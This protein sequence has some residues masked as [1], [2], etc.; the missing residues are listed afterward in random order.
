MF[1][2][3]IT[4]KGFTMLLATS[5]VVTTILAGC[6]NDAELKAKDMEIARLQAQ[7]KELREQSHDTSASVPRSVGEKIRPIS[8]K[9]EDT[10]LPSR[11][12]LEGFK[13]LKK[14]MTIEQTYRT[15]QRTAGEGYTN[16]QGGITYEFRSD[17]G[18]ISIKINYKNDKMV[19]ADYI[20]NKGNHEIIK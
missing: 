20:D 18:S 15:L 10:N 8:I 7:L 13:E 5:L 19:S 12:N 14:G 2:K 11:I 9:W 1:K 3:I 16:A 17:T 6:G 4:L